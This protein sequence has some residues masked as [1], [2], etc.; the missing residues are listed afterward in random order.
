MYLIRSIAQA[1]HGRRDEAVAVLKEFAAAATADL[2]LKSG[3]FLTGSIGP[4]DSTV[5]MEW[6]EESLAS[7]EVGLDKIN[8]WPKM[9]QFGPRFTEVFVSASHRFEIYRIS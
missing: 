5:V 1:N 2:G 7:F 3:R 6:E 4:N 9:A 8:S